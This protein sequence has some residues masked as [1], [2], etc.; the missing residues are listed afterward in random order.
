M[1]QLL[2]SEAKG[3]SGQKVSPRGC[4]LSLAGKQA[5]RGLADSQ[6]CCPSL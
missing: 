5:V 2:A 1:V 4:R 3:S 6:P